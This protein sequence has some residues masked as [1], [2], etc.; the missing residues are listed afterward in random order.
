M[1]Q[2]FLIYYNFCIIIIAFDW[3]IRGNGGNHEDL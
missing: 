1:I 3:E 2:K